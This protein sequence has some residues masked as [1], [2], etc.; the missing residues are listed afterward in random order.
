MTSDIRLDAL[1]VGCIKK[2]YSPS[3]E[4]ILKAW[5]RSGHRRI[6][7]AFKK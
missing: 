5:D 3:P 4:D 2:E 7:L 6:S 1:A